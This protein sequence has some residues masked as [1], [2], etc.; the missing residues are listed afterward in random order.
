MLKNTADIKG[1][2]DSRRKQA[3]WDEGTLEKI[4]LGRKFG[5]N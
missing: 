1:S 2:I 3:G 5:E 4:L